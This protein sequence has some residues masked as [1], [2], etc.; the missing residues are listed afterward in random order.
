MAHCRHRMHPR[1]HNNIMG[2]SDRGRGW[3]TYAVSLVA[4][5]G[6][7]LDGAA[8][9]EIDAPAVLHGAWWAW[10][11]GKTQGQHGARH[12]PPRRHNH[13]VDARPAARSLTEEEAE[14]LRKE[15]DWMVLLTFPLAELK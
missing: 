11:S 8:S 12:G 15:Q 7:G 3:I 5:E 13:T 6:A 10:S 4:E 2:T 9:K 1:R 14:L